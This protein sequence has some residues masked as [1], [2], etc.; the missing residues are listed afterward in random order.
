MTSLLTICSFFR[1]H[2]HELKIP[3]HIKK[4]FNKLSLCLPQLAGLQQCTY[5]SYFRA[6]S[7]KFSLVHLRGVDIN[8][9]HQIPK[10]AF[11][12]LL[13]KPC[14]RNGIFGILFYQLL[15]IY[16]GSRSPLQTTMDFQNPIPYTVLIIVCLEI[17][18]DVFL[19]KC[20]N[21]LRYYHSAVFYK[22]VDFQFS[23]IILQSVTTQE[24]H[25]DFAFYLNVLPLNSLIT[26]TVKYFIN[27]EF[28]LI[29]TRLFCALTI[30]PRSKSEKSFFIPSS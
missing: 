13:F 29:L 25:E 9:F 3:K 11:S 27:M 17:L 30:I 20:C 1:A 12:Y 22:S 4:T 15:L 26:V 6:F 2:E 10:L 23:P 7:S 18:E 14:F 19:L 28:S 8:F 16:L 24:T 5:R 21:L